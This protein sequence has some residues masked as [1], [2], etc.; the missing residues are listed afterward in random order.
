ME[1]FFGETGMEGKR[2]KSSCSYV[3][4]IVPISFLFVASER[5]AETM[6]NYL[7]W[8]QTKGCVLEDG[9]SSPNNAPK[10]NIYIKRLCY[11][12]KLGI[13]LNSDFLLCLL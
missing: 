11:V 8:Q 7:R 13:N 5:T 1:F 2:T 6:I 3:L 4:Y 10:K 12:S 9:V